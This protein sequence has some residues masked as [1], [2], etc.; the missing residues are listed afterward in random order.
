MKKS[1]LVILLTVFNISIVL[2][3]GKTISGKLVDQLSRQKIE[4]ASIS[5][6]KKDSTV[7]KGTLSDTLGNFEFRDVPNNLSFI[8][9]QALSYKTRTISLQEFQASKSHEISLEA[10]NQTLNEIIVKGEKAV[11]SLQIDKQTFQT[12]Q[13]QNAANGTG[14]DLMQRLPAVTINTE[15]EIS[16]RG[17]SGFILLVDGKPS[18]R[19]PADILA[20]LPANII[21]SI[22][23]ITS[24]SAK[25]DADGKAGMINIITK[26][27]TRIGTAWSGNI[28]NG[29]T[30]PLRFGSD[31]QWTFTDK[32]WSVFAAADYRRYDID[33]YRVGEIRT[34]YQDTLTYMPSVGVRNYMD[35]QYSIRAGGSFQASSKDIWNWSAYMGEKQTDRTANLHYQDFIN[36]NPSRELFSAFN[37]N[38][39]PYRQFYNQ[40]LFVR[41]GKFQTYNIDYT[42]TYA[43][44]GKLSLLGLYEYSKLGGPLNN[45]DTYEGNNKLLLW[46]RSTETSPLNAWRFQ[47]DYS[48]PLRANNKLEFG[49]HFRHLNHQGDFLFER[50]AE[51]T[52]SW[53]SDPNYTDKME[54]VQR[55]HAPYIQLNGS[56]K[57]FSYALG[58]RSEW[59]D[60][61]LTHAGEPGKTYALNQVYLFPSLQGI[62]KLDGEKTLRIGYSR[63]IERPTSKL[64]SPFKNHRHAETVETG[65]PNLLPEIANVVE[66]GLSKGFENFSFTATAYVNFLHDKVFRVNEIY[67]RT[68]LGRTYTNAGNSQSTGIEFLTEYRPAKIWKVYLSGNL[69]QFDVQGNFRGIETQQSSFN[70]NLNGNTSLDISPKLR[71]AWDFTYLSKS[72]TTQGH[73]SD[74]LLSNVSLKYTL[75]ENRANLNLQ[76][77]NVFNSNIQTIVTQTPTFF[78][79]TDYRKWD[80]VIQL[81]FGF[82]I[83]DRGQKTKSTKTEYG[84][85]EF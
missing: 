1:L 22:E 64:M 26:K 85:K 39:V 41:S 60:R 31:L 23:L 78:S 34:K 52:S 29:G 32:K 8:K 68:I 13:F 12:K 55:I 56:N 65:D 71:F 5:L 6:W 27:N 51:G 81:S 38:Q 42:H 30:L 16:L 46:E 75:W 21:E 67:S 19:T 10:E 33:G 40:N 77:L 59:M 44:Q 50:F 3:Q 70:Y 58:L 43:N 25:Y 24:P 36:T 35:F 74:L 80:R 45:Y 2:S 62:W 53:V 20:Q 49:Y 15:G 54:L 73:D 66:V 61:T 83:N 79:S 48:L 57:Q 84:E 18:T 11:A 37:T 47:V 17:S 82:R 9:F 28:M 14:M 69:Y 4:F 7:W 76:C 63:R 72:V